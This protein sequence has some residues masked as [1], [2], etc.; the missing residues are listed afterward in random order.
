MHI[1]D[2]I[3]PTRVARPGMTVADIF[4]E[5]VIR[6]V[7]GIPYCDSDGRMVGRVSIRHTLKLTCIPEY[8]VKGAHLLKDAV[9][10]L[11]LQDDKI[12]AVLSL[13]VEFYVL[14]D[15]PTVSSASPIVKALSIMERYN[16]GYVFLM[17][18]GEYKGIVTRMGIARL[19]LEKR[20]G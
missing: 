8:V 15:T 12:R 16:S 13:P 9:E 19:L 17:D 7:P 6:N 10:Q 14:R 18:D 20:Q 1:A 2:I 4:E 5:C 3:V 11:N